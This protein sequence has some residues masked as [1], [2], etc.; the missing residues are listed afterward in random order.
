M[1]IEITGTGSVLPPRVMSN[2]ELAA[3]ID[4]SDEWIRSHT[5]IGKRHLVN[6]DTSCSDLALNAAVKALAMAAGYT[7]ESSEEQYRAALDI[8]QTLDLIVLGTATSDYIGCPSTACIVQDRLKAY[9]AGAMDIS[10]GCSGFIYG[11]ETAA[12][13]LGSGA[14]RKRALVIGAEVLSKVLDWDDRGTCIVFGDGAG[15]VVIEKT[16]TPANERRGLIRSV[17]NA[18]GSGYD[19]LLFRRGGTRHPFKAGETIDKPVHVEMNGQEVYYF[20]VKAMI[21]TIEK[22]LAEERITIDDVKLIVPHQANIRI[23][24]SAAR[25]LKIPMK[26]FYLNI[27]EC[28]N[29]SAASIPIAL[30]ELN[31]ANQLKHGDLIMTVGFGGGFT[32]GGNIIIW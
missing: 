24:Q 18:D 6:E 5:G 19:K 17:L 1:A 7:N 32:Y 15:A 11:L 2:D 23:I 3:R 22:L 29:T 21:A 28:A 25:G 4:T 26:K 13:L 16:E 8:S 20:A 27:E 10:A 30:D 12:S 9:K 31:R 14:E